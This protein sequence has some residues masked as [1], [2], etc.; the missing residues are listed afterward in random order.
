M[1]QNQK[2]KKSRIDPVKLTV[3]I[4]SV[5]VII[6]VSIWFYGVFVG[7]VN[8]FLKNG[9]VGG[10]VTSFTKPIYPKK[11]E[12]DKTEYDLRMYHLAHKFNLN[13]AT[14]TALFKESLKF[15][16]PTSAGISPTYANTSVVGTSSVINVSNGT[17][18]I[19]TTK[20]ANKKDISSLW[21]VKSTAYP[22][23]G[24]ILPFKRVVAYY[25]N[26]YSRKMG[27]LGEYESNEVLQRLKSQVKEWEIA[28]PTTPVQ[29]ALH[30]IAVV[31]Q[32]S[33]GK[34]GKYRAR[35]TDAEIEKVLEMAKKI[36]AI[37]FL[38]IQV[39]L[40]DVE[41]E[42]PPLEKYLSLPNVHLGIDPEFSMKTGK[43][44][45]SVIG[46]M[47]AED[48]NYTASYLAGLVKKHDLPPKILTFYRFTRNMVTN[49]KNIKT[50]PEVQLVLTMDGWGHQARKIGTYN[51]FVNTE[52][53]QFTGFKIFYKNDLKQEN[54]RLMT[55][56]EVI[57]LTPAPIY[58]QYQ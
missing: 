36:D 47:D 33:A 20:V 30:Y 12:L 4:V 23:V 14:S 13:D 54:S 27:I 38:D 26:L 25:G 44:P 7:I 48:I 2:R 21:P 34:D 3:L 29:P 43:K 19:T 37:V 5:I 11:P 9:G 28:D 17:S 1:A 56:S 46:T 50:I 52:P 31:A 32:G 35:M 40:S 49:Y 15:A 41:R 42:L 39:A 45:G 6:C 55:P 53:I 22:K 24:A 8:N 16:S 51:A 18:T 58:I 10:I 57:E